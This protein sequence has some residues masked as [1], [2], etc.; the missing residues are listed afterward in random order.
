MAERRSGG[1]DAWVM[2]AG[3]PISDSTPPSDSARANSFVRSTNR[4]TQL[5]FQS[6]VEGVLERWAA[7]GQVLRVPAS[8]DFE[9]RVASALRELV[10]EA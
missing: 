4:F 10:Q 6:L 7:P 8:T 3:T 1:T 5:R 9:E 2:M